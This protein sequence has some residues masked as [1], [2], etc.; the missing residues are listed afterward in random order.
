MRQTYLEINLNNFEHNI[1]EIKKLHPNKEIIPVIKANAYGTHINKHIDTINKFNIVAVAIVE[2]AVYLRNLGY[3]KDILVLNQPY[4]EDLPNIIKYDISIG[5][6]YLDYIKDIK[7]KIK[8]HIEIESGMNRT[9]FKKEE[10]QE[11]LSNI[12]DN[13][14]IEGIYTHFSSAENDPEYTNKQIDYFKECV[15]ILK[16]YQKEIKYIHSSA[17]NG[18]V[19]YNLDFTNAIRPGIIMY[20]YYSSNEIK[21]KINIKP[22]AKL[23]SKISYLKEIDE[24]ESVSYNR[25]YKTNKKTKIATIGI[26]Y[27]DGYP[28]S[29]SNIG[30]VVINN[31]LCN[32][33]GR[34]CMDSILVDV[35]DLNEVKIGDKVYLFD[36]N[37]V[38]LEEL[39]SYSNTINYEIL[40]TIHE[41]VPRIYIQE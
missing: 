18:L 13:I 8:I 21:E 28:R 14:K 32:V 40:S 9:G 36:N 27:A 38:T 10:L 7:D 3:K 6:S 1:N 15:S 26:G 23:I 41:R 22:I 17:S 31:K 37:L 19:N 33:I 5:L 39:A 34:V 30:R 16:D 25:T 29:A 4:I 20:G 24:N 35:T 12:N 2:E 11:L